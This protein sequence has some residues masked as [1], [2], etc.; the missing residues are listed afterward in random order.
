MFTF[1]VGS[2]ERLITD[3]L[4]RA[5]MTWPAGAFRTSKTEVIAGPPFGG[6]GDGVLGG[7]G[8]EVGD[9]DGVRVGLGVTVG[10]APGDT[11]GIGVGGGVVGMGVG[12]R[13]GDGLL[14]GV[15]DANPHT[16]SFE[17]ELSAPKMS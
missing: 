14:V 10:D 7:V 3:P 11:D 12:V 13:V 5:M 4:P 15:G 6:A 8:A 2:V 16:T 17:K 9:G 1:C